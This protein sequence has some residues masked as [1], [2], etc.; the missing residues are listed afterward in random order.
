MNLTRPI[1]VVDRRT[2]RIARKKITA[3]MDQ[4]EYTRAKFGLTATML[5]LRYEVRTGPK[6]HRVRYAADMEQMEITEAEVN[7]LLRLTA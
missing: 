5:W 2:Y 3:L 4:G 7:K 6:R 1:V